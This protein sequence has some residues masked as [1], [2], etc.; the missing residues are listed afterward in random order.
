MQMLTVPATLDSLASISE[1]V[2]D[3]TARAGLDEHAA[4][5]VQLAVDEAATNIIQHGYGPDTRGDIELSWRIEGAHLVVMLRDQG[6]SFDPSEIPP[7]D[8]ESP[9][10]ERQAGGLG[11]FLMGKL[12][13]DVRFEFDG[14]R[15]NLLTMT[16]RIAGARPQV[17]EFN[18]SGRLDAIAASEAT[19]EPR[20]AVAEG[21]RLML[22][23]LSEVTFMSSSGLRALL[24][25]R[26]ELL[27]RGGE[28]R[29]ASMKPQVFE[30]FSLTGFTQIF[31]IHPTREDALAAFDQGNV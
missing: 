26:K 21:V 27:A 20:R 13:D 24:L 9:L 3:A 30:V 23:D 14:Q 15:G 5:Q 18:L 22:L 1:F 6:R 10:E 31:N 16:K 25:L 19:R 2:T 7:P 28:L 12:M 17:H 11:L 4:W 29:L 8:I